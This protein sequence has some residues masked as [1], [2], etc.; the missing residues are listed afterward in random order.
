M[1]NKR[2][3]FAI[4][5]ILVIICLGWCFFKRKDNKKEE[6]SI[7]ITDESQIEEKKQYDDIYVTVAYED[8][9]IYC[10][11][12]LNSTDSFAPHAEY[13]TYHKHTNEELK[14]TDITSL[15]P[16]EI[17]F[18]IQ[19]QL[20]ANYPDYYKEYWGDSDVSTETY[21]EYQNSYDVLKLHFCPNDNNEIYVF[22][23]WDLPYDS[24]SNGADVCI[25]LQR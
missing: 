4:L 12:I 3:L 15:S 17:F 14:I 21:Y 25:I 13:H 24:Y 6:D 18:E 9:K 2:Y 11:K 10:I 16:E 23:P 5:L 20:K 1:K 8:D 19:T 7:G 22:D